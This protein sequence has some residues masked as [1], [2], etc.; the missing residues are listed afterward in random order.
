MVRSIAASAALEP[1]APHSPVAPSADR[2]MQE[3]YRAHGR[4]LY[5]FLLRLTLGDTHA[6]EDLMQETLTRAW[7]NLDRLNS[8]LETLRPWLITVARRIAIDASRAKHARP[9]ESGA[10][11]M[12]YVPENEN[13]IERMLDRHVVGQALVE[14]SLEHRT[15]ILEIYYR[16]RSVS[17]VAAL[18][19]I[20]EGTV[21]SRA[22][23]AVRMLRTQLLSADASG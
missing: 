5:H 13:A 9:P 15:V 8:D 10:I 3:L 12:S 21:K 2:R 23:N 6:A 11:D 4:P 17:E 20:P 16:G 18:L 14:L 1:M 19:G 22:F 7:R